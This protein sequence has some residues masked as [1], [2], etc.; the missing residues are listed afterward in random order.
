MDRAPARL[1]SSSSRL[2]A[3]AVSLVGSA[4]RVRTCMN[5]SQADFGDYCSGAREPN[6]I[7]RGRLI[8]LIVAE[9]ARIIAANRTLLAALRS[10]KRP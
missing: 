6:W 10:G 3:V 1:P 9:H 2:I 5:C 8:D 7:E 4:E